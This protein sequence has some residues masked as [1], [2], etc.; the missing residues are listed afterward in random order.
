VSFSEVT[1]VKSRTCAVAAGMRSAGSWCSVNCRANR[2]ISC[3]SG[4]SR[5]LA[6]ARVSQSTRLPFNR[7]PPLECA[8]DCY[9]SYINNYKYNTLVLLAGPG[10]LEAIQG[11]A[12]SCKLLRSAR[13]FRPGFFLQFKHNRQTS[14]RR[15]LEGFD[16]S[17]PVDRAVIGR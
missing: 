14:L 15:R 10:Y 2:A 7:I 16:S 1:S 13:R 8:E 5:V 11:L 17:G 12:R 3:V 4:A 6:V 9:Y